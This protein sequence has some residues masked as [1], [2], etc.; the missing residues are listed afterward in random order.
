MRS[1]A[2]L[3]PAINCTVTSG[4]ASGTGCSASYLQ[5]TAVTLTA[6]PASENTFTG[7]SGDC[8]GSTCVITMAAN[9]AATAAFGA[10]PGPE[11]TNGQWEAAHNTMTV[12]GMHLIQLPSGKALMWGHMGEPQLWNGPG[13]GFTQVSNTTC[14]NPSLCELFCAGHAF[15]SDGKVLVAGGHNED[16]GDLNGIKQASVFDGTSW[17]ATGS[18]YYARW[19]PTLVTLAN[20]DV[21]ALAGSISPGVIATIPER[22][23]GSGGTWTRLTGINVSVPSYSRAFV[24]PKAGNVFVADGNAHN[25]NLAGS[26][27]WTAGP[28]PIEPD[29][30]YA[31]V[32][33]LDSKVLYIGG[34]GGN[35]CTTNAPKKTAEIIDLAAATPAWAPTGSLAI[36]RRQANATILAD[37][38][39]LVTGGTSLCGFSNEAGAVFA[40]ELW[41]PETG[42]WRT[43]SAHAQV[44][45]VYH[46]ATMLLAD[47]RVFSTGGG[48]GGG[49]VSQHSYEIFSPPYLFN[50]P[51]PTYNLARNDMH[52]GQPFVVA[53]PNA[54]SIR[55]VNLIRLAAS[56]HTFDMGQR[57][58]TLSFVASADGQSLTLTAPAAGR[59]APPGPYR[60]FIV[61]DKGVPSVGQ[62]VYLTP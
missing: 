9:R 61:N 5:G 47:G 50:G 55:K 54:A 56:T 28:S 26:G 30:G 51:R 15:L 12:V 58:N 2:G 6:T 59:I 42:Q 17:Q 48:D 38:S 10:P 8:T 43:L 16:L 7:W 57:L 62:T 36:G 22:Y 24:E 14:V 37:G 3:T 41:N 49:L 27:S 44:V 60:I 32:V 45:R 39:V 33:M 25:F 23:N 31:P 19:Y 53:T 13:Q 29:R 35:N 20:G 52:Y 21:L 34:G 1:Q 18:M 4:S 11:A 46:S 40:P